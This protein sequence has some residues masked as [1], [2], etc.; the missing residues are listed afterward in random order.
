MLFLRVDTVPRQLVDYFLCST[1]T[2]II[3]ITIMQRLTRRV[4][5]TRV[6]NRRRISSLTR[7]FCSRRHQ[8]VQSCGGAAARYLYC[9]SLL[10]VCVCVCVFSLRQ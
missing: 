4:S 5:V 2:F 7:L 8:Q 9:S 10:C 1:N 3:T 6:T